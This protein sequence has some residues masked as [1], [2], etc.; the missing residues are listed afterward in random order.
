MS[1]WVW[2]DIMGKEKWSYL[3]RILLKIRI[4]KIEGRL[5]YFLFPVT[6]EER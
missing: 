6:A 5:D 3:S 1:D 2:Q 4:K